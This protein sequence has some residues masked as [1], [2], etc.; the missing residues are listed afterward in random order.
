[1]PEQALSGLLAASQELTFFG[2]THMQGG[3]SHRHSQP[4]IIALR[5]PRGEALFSTLLLESG[6]RYLLNPGSIGQPRDGDPRA[7]FAI[8]DFNQ[9]LVEFWRVPYDIA[10]VQQRMRQA[11]LPEHL[12]ARLASGH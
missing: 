12:V 3:F 1:V 5:R 4:E 10:S 6:T 11:G 2:H 7:A 8:V 9:S